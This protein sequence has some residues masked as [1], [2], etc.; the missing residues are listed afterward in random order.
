MGLVASLALEDAL[1]VKPN[2]N[3]VKIRN[4]AHGAEYLQNIIRQICIFV[5]PDYVNITLVPGNSDY[6]FRLPEKYT[7]K[8]N[9]DY[10]KAHR[11]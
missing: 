7:E 6:D 2:E 5:F 1:K 10:I 9:S 4:F 11:M 8:I 3:G